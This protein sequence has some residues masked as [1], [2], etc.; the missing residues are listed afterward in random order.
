[1]ERIYILP[2]ACIFEQIVNFNRVQLKTHIIFGDFQC[3]IQQVVNIHANCSHTEPPCFFS[4][5]TFWLRDIVRIVYQEY[6][7]ENAS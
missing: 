1:M 6:G 5:T 2:V 3:F 4:Q 7:G